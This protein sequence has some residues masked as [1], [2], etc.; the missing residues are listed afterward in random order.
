MRRYTVRDLEVLPQ[1]RIDVVDRAGED[2]LTLITCYPFGGLLRS[3]WRLVI[4]AT[5]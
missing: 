5:P 3:R 1:G 4:A 2:R